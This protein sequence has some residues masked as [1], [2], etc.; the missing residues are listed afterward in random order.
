MGLARVP[1]SACRRHAE[2]AYEVRDHVRSLRRKFSLGLP[3]DDRDPFLPREA[4][5]PVPGCVR[6]AVLTVATFQTSVRRTL[7]QCDGRAPPPTWPKNQDCGDP[8]SC[9]GNLT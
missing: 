3:T 4:T 7:D 8:K 1:S 5:Y 2:R 6:F 9:V